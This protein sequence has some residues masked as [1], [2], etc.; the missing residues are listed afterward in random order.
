MRIYFREVRRRGLLLCRPVGMPSYCCSGMTVAWG[1]FLV[2]GSQGSPGSPHV[3]HRVQFI[4]ATGRSSGKLMAVMFCPFCGAAIELIN[5]TSQSRGLPD[6][7][8][9]PDG[10]GATIN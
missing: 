2:M 3:Y 1:D 7:G 9:G 8:E 10:S 4:V 6:E 5:V